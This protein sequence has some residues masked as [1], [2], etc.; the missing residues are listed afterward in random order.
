[1]PKIPAAMRRIYRLQVSLTRSEADELGALLD[2]IKLRQEEDTFRIAL[3]ERISCALTQA[4]L[5]ARKHK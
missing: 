4:Y 2:G 5:S 1:M 3:V